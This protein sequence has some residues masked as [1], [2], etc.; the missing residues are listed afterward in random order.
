[1]FVLCVGDFPSHCL[2]CLCFFCVLLESD[3]PWCMLLTLL[4]SAYVS[5]RFVDFAILTYV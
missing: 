1:M 5:W 4:S 2:L 3:I